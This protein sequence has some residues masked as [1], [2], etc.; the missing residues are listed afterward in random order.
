MLSRLIQITGFK[1]GADEEND[2]RLRERAVLS[3]ERFSTAGSK[4]AYTYQILSS[5]AKVIE[6][7]VANGGAGIVNIHLK[8]TDMS[9]ETRSSVEAYL[10]ADKVRPLTDNVV[11]KNATVNDITVNAELEL[12]D[13][14][15][16]A[17]IDKQIKQ[18]RN[19]L[20]LGEDLN[21]SY[22][23]SLLHKNGVYRVNLKSPNADTKVS[24]DT[25]VKLNFN[26]TYKKA[27]LCVGLQS[28]EFSIKSVGHSLSS[29]SYSV[30]IEFEG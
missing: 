9:E 2:E 22:I 11:V 15:L 19:S 29:T 26:L 1:G 7:N 18:S 4:K 14:F 16:Q 6:A 23:Y 20:S 24:Q 8:T 3:L 10:S 21:L 28:S 27:E 13:M 5:N 17:E 12:T 25:F 30:E